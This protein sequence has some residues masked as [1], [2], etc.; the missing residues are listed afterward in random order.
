MPVTRRVAPALSPDH[1]RASLAGQRSRRTFE[2]QRR[3]QWL[4]GWSD[5][6]GGD[7]AA[8]EC[9]TAE[10][11]ITNRKKEVAWPSRSRSWFA[12]GRSWLRANLTTAV[13]AVAA[14]ATRNSPPA[15]APRVC[16][17]APCL[18]ACL[19]ACSCV[20]S[21][22][23]HV[24]VPAP[25]LSPKVPAPAPAPALV[26]VE[27]SSAAVQPRRHAACAPFFCP[28]PPSGDRPVVTS[29]RCRR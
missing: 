12:G 7:H 27:R 13:V 29:G 20:A 24:R 6:G 10:E 21:A 1:V 3:R 9:S 18:P 5:G 28:P 2:S 22:A 19:L 11:L 14:A 17:A 16:E 15:C 23:R 25:V 26:P 8:A 4:W